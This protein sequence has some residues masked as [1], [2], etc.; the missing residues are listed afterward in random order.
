MRN[1]S[2]E[3]N[4]STDVL[5]F[6]EEFF[7]LCI[8]IYKKTDLYNILQISESSFNHSFVWLIMG[9]AADSVNEYNLKFIPGEYIL[10]APKE[11]NKVDACIIDNDMEICLLETSGKLL[12]RDNTKYGFDHIKCNFGSLN[13]FNNIYKKHY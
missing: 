6:V 11:T 8:S 5:N 10:M 3:E 1:S 12:L 9:F 13:I 4:S 2:Y 7:E